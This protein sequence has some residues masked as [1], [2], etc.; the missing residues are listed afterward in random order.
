M[1]NM[2]LKS[3]LQGLIDKYIIPLEENN[4]NL[5]NIAKDANYESIYKSVSDLRGQV[6]LKEYLETIT[7][8]N[9]LKTREA[10]ITMIQKGDLEKILPFIFSTEDNQ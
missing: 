1:E 9:M 10:F 8:F 3:R 4:K 7:N 5:N 2:A 6:M